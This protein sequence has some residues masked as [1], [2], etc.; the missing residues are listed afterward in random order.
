MKR[1]LSAALPVALIA[2]AAI[3]SSAAVAADDPRVEAFATGFVDGADPDDPDTP[4]FRIEERLSL[5]GTPGLGVAIIDDGEIV[6][7]GGYG[8]QQAGGDDAI[9]AD[10]VFSVGSVS[11]MVNA[12]LILRL[13]VEGAVDLDTDVNEY[14]T[15]WKVPDNRHTRKKK[16]TLRAILSHTA[17]FNVHGFPDFQPGAALP[18]AI[19]TLEGRRPAKNRPVRVTFVP[20]DHMD[21]SGGGITVSQVLVEDVTGMSYEA[22]AR[23]YV[24]EPLGMTRSTFENP[25]PASHGDIARAHDQQGRPAAA[26]RGWEAMPE[27]AASGLW[28]SANDLAL[29]VQALIKSAQGTDDFLPAALATDMMTRVPN[30]WH[31]LGPRLNGEGPTRVFHHGG[32]NDSYRAWI[33]GHLTTGDGA[34]FLTNSRGGHFVVREARR[35]VGEAFDWATSIE[36]DYEEPAF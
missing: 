30:S 10:T 29:F 2:A 23:K 18:S 19:D 6:W 5:H 34:V 31:G 9:G 3:A 27:M 32:A 22:A 4:R 14:L 1:I 17:G 11:K 28:T 25:L 7:A 8:R 36:D 16:V 26:P 21:Y 15:S 12:A 13:A 35:S 33:E 24:F 20:G